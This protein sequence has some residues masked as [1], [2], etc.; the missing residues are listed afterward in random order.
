M[1]LYTK[2]IDI[3]KLLTAWDRVKKNKP[4]CGVDRITWEQYDEDKKEQVKKLNREL[5]DH[6]YEVLPVK[7][8]TLYKDGKAREV[9]LY[10][11][12]DKNVQQSVAQELT[13]IYD[14]LFSSRTFAYRPGKSALNALSE[15]EEACKRGECKWCLKLDI[16]HYFDTIDVVR[17]KRM[18]LQQIHEDDVLE[19]IVKECTT[20]SLEDDG[21]LTEKRRGI[22]QGS[23]IAPILSNV[24]LREFDIE[25]AAR[26]PFYVRY[27]DDILVLTKS[28]EEAAAALSKATAWMG[29]LGLELNEKKTCIKL[30][31]DGFEFLGYSFDDTG[32]SIPSKATDSLVE[33]LET[34]WYAD[35][36]LS[37][38]DK[39]KKG[40][41]I[42]DGWQ[43]YFRGERDIKSIYE[44]ATILYMTANKGV[45]VPDSVLE[46]RKTL[47]NTDKD[48]CKW[49]ACR[50]MKSSD[51]VRELAE[52]E[53]FYGM[54]GADADTNLGEPYLGLVLEDYRNLIVEESEE[55][56]TDLMQQ[57][58]DAGCYNRAARMMDLA[59]EYRN[60]RKNRA[61]PVITLDED[62]GATATVS[63]TKEQLDAYY[64]NFVG[65]DDIYSEETVGQGGRRVCNPVLE[66]L[67]DDVLK[68]HFAGNIT[69]CTYVQ[70]TNATV[71][72]LVI[73]ADISKKTLLEVGDSDAARQP[74]L[75]KAA[76]LTAAICKELQHMGLTGYVEESGFRGYH[77]WVLF[78][79]WISTRYAQL[80]EDIID[81]RFEDSSELSIEYFPNKT[82]VNAEKPGQRIKLPYGFHVKT[83]RPSRFLDEDFKPVSDPGA[84]IMEM[85]KATPSAVKKVIGSHAPKEVVGQSANATVDE[86]LTAFAGASENVQMV[87]KNCTLMRYLCQKARKTGYLSH[88]ERLSVLYVFGHLGDDGKDFVH[89]VMKFTLN[90]QYG[91][92]QKFINRMPEKPISCAK[93]RDQYQKVTAECGCSC[94]FNRI[95]NCYP[96]PVLHAIKSGDGGQGITLPTSRSLSKEKAAAVSDE[97]NIKKQVQTTAGKILEYK[98]QKRAIDKNIAKLE[99]ELCKIFDEAGLNSMEIDCGLLV[100]RKKGD[101][102]EWVVEI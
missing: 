23:A 96:S 56:F 68:R 102:Y 58:T 48:I 93:L 27:S 26:F 92:T 62:G 37:I 91:I 100:R 52:Y 66:P 101:G 38:T 18:L 61:K 51:S 1:S 4:A 2:I 47:Q 99:G 31:K 28:Q 74:Y 59:N 30:I 77:I 85:A 94:N 11:M 14:C 8:V 3:Q 20:P 87:L 44:Y 55:L 42:L 81:A 78:T 65:R 83:G 50:W 35:R 36:K 90:Y 49:I 22:Y 16:H 69:A 76:N 75:Q 95:K 9:A 73:D 63:F 7:L 34:A 88:F 79:E 54:D 40:S 86:D 32:K 72:Y 39:L 67:D 84:Y 60:A 24:Y 12:R 17:L 25:M 64:A 15:I 41:E 82:R 21:T 80:L 71:K 53:D 10:S 33:R 89:T 98:K 43:Q 70:R 29:N 46:Q 57:Y 45:E 19:L 13:N 6:N 97:L 5:V